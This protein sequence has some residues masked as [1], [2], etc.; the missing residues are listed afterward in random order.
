MKTHLSRAMIASCF[1]LTA[2]LA[3]GCGDGKKPAT[4]PGN[5]KPVPA[6]GSGASA[7]QTET[8]E[9]LKALMTETLAA[10]G[11]EAG[12]KQLCGAMVV[13]DHEKFFA[14]TFGPEQGKA[15]AA[16][17]GKSAPQ[18][19]AQ[20]PALFKRIS[21]KGQTDIN[22]R[23]LTDPDGSGATGLQQTALKAMK[24]KT[25]LYSVRFVK[26]GDKS[27]MHIWSFV[28]VDGEFR[29]AGKMRVLMK[30]MK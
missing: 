17:Y 29:L 15:L 3:S 22:I 6:T 1:V 5:G 24:K 21:S 27:G 28:F 9:S 26:P 30:L 10:V 4:K 13:P 20:L 2:L 19:G 14:D 11:N 7:A 12:M 25:A 16:E 18:L 23:K 8:V